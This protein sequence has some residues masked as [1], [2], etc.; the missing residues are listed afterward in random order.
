MSLWMRE[1]GSWTALLSNLRKAV[2]H[3]DPSRHVDEELSCWEIHWGFSS[4]DTMIIG[5]Q[6]QSELTLW[7]RDSQTRIY[8]PSS[9]G[10]IF[11]IVWTLN[12]WYGQFQR[13]IYFID[14]QHVKFSYII[15][16]YLCSCIIG[17]VCPSSFLCVFSSLSHFFF[18]LFYIYFYICIILIF[19]IAILLLWFSSYLQT[20]SLIPKIW[21]HSL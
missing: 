5:V 11:K 15:H 20:H 10:A 2:K 12:Y 14:L 4:R 16:C 1:V 8:R 7:S 6:P 21:M 17:S 9:T 3:C 19:N 13:G 18:T